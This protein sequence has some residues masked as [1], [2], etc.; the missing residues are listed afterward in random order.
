MSYKEDELWASPYAIVVL[1]DGETYSGTIGS[2]VYLIDD[3]IN[4]NDYDVSTFA[5]EISNHPCVRKL[6][7]DRL[8]E[9]YLAFQAMNIHAVNVQDDNLNK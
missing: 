5:E 8:V 6:S 3:A 2:Y 7:I 1:D 9:F 4:E